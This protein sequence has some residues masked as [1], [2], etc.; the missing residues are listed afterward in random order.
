MEIQIPLYLEH[1][2]QEMGVMST[3]HEELDDPVNG[4]TVDMSFSGPVGSFD[5]FGEP[6]W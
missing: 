1:H 3:D 4:T 5:E 6:Q 2:L